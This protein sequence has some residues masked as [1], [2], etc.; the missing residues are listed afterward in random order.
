GEPRHSDLTGTFRTA[1]LRNT[2]STGTGSLRLWKHSS[3]SS[4][5]RRRRGLL[6]GLKKGVGLVWDKIAADHPEP[7]PVEKALTKEE[8]KAKHL[9][10]EIER[11]NDWHTNS[12]AEQYVLQNVL[13]MEEVK[14]T[15]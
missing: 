7:L 9:Q 14:I 8:Q 6:G 12:V 15:R 5:R 2:S 4:E 13:L 11:R 3:S 10:R 1:S